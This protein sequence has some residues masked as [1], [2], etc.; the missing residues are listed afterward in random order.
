[1]RQ[2]RFSMFRKFAGGLAAVFTAFAASAQDEGA[3]RA[4]VP[5]QVEE[6]TVVRDDTNSRISVR[7]L[8]PPGRTIS[9][10]DVQAREERFKGMG[11]LLTP[12]DAA[13]ALADRLGTACTELIAHEPEEK[14][15]GEY[16]AIFARADCPSL[17]A[18]GRPLT[19]MAMAWV[20]KTDLQ[21]KQMM[22]KGTPDAVQIKY[23]M[24]FLSTPAKEITWESDN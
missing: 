16:A 1:M 6:W 3:K 19:I 17:K 4:D 22:F 21:T 9:D 23:A 20:E 14:Q 7:T 18:T 8:V 2:V 12:S 10:W 5:V 13:D 24:R 15:I 11:L